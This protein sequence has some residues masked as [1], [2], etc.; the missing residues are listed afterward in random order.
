M[1]F[2]DVSWKM[3][4]VRGIIGVLFGIVAIA[5]PI[6][7]ALTLVVVWGVWAI[8]DGITLAVEGFSKGGAGMKVLSAVMAVVAL[9]AGFYAIIHP[10]TAL[11]ALTWVLGIWLIV[12]GVFELVGAFGRTSEGRSR[13]VLVLSALID[14][15][16]GALFVTHPG[17][18]A[19]GLALLLGIIAVAWGLVLIVLAFMTRSSI[20]D[21]DK[22]QPG[23]A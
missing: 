15:V 5:W 23:Y 16:L 22:S 12:R 10:G 3:L 1:D 21:L 9:I 20:K 14:F 18:S 17:K 11:V 6:G 19:L 8:I 4:L 7:T 2:F 13:W